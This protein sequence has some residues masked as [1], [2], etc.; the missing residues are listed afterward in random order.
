M[1]KQALVDAA[2]RKGAERSIHVEHVIAQSQVQVSSSRNVEV[3]SLL[4]T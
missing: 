3:P 2:K 1:H 4:Q